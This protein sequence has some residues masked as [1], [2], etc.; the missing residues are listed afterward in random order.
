[1]PPTSFCASVGAF[2]AMKS[3]PMRVTR[4]EPPLVTASRLGKPPASGVMPHPAQP[5]E[6]PPPLHAATTTKK[7]SENA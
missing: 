6:H 3:R 4:A 5:L 1:M 7:S 2:A